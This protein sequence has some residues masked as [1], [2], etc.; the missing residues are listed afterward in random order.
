MLPDS[1]DR[2]PACPTLQR[3]TGSPQD[4]SVRLADLKPVSQVGQDG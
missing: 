4:E 3:P 1:A 2:L